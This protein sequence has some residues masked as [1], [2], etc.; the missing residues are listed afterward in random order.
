MNCSPG[1][2][3]ALVW[4]YSIVVTTINDSRRQTW[5]EMLLK[6]IAIQPDKDCGIQLLRMRSDTCPDCACNNQIH[7]VINRLC[8]AVK[9]II[10]PQLGLSRAI[11]RFLPWGH[12]GHFGTEHRVRVLRRRERI[13]RRSR[14]PCKPKKVTISKWPWYANE[15]FSNRRLNCGSLQG[16]LKR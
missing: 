2:N 9:S 10:K 1:D 15:P 7:S 5:E 11:N 8:F 4:W 12:L 6:V 13:H 3:V 16:D 14:Q